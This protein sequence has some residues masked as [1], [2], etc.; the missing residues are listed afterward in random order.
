MSKITLDSVASGYDLSKINN[1][2][3][4][5]QTAIDNTLSRDGTTPNTVEADIDMNGYRLLNLLASDGEGFVWQG[6]WVTATA[7]TL[8]S[9]VSEGGSS[10]ICTTD[11]TSGTFATDLAAGKWALL[12]AKGASGAGTGDMLASNN[13]S[14]VSSIST[15]RANLGLVIG[16]D[17]QAQ[18]ATLSAVAALTLSQGC[19]ISATAADAPVVIAKGTA[20]QQLR[21]NAGATAP[22]WFTPASSSTGNPAG[23]IIDYGGSAAPTGY[24]PCDGAA[25]SRTTYADLFTAI[26]TLWG[27]GDGSTTFNVPAFAAGDAAVQ[28][29]GTV[30]ASTDGQIPSHTHTISTNGGGGAPGDTHIPGLSNAAGTVS[31][32]SLGTYSN[33]G[34][35]TRNFAAG[36]RVLK[37]VKY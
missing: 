7:Y 11:H 1:N 28:S 32:L 30:G 35:G 29:A 19:L 6:A 12:A 36:K 15:A 8:N 21:M 33:T 31:N 26:G 5:L 23:T 16:T 9:L 14:D 27:V 4:I 25:V 2:F 10:Y 18:D 3:Q 20:S 22:E 13:L 34:S 24:L 37:C 17:V